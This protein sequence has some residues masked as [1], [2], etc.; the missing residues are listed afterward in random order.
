MNFSFS[1]RFLSVFFIILPVVGTIYS[2][3]VWKKA[4]HNESPPNR[5]TPENY[6]STSSI[7]KDLSTSEAERKHSNESVSPLLNVSDKSQKGV[8]VFFVLVV[9]LLK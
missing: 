1:P 2:A 6:G 4:R 3:R 9:A 5:L 8:V 7:Q